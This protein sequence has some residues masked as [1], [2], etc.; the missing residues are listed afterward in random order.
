MWGAP[1]AE[2]GKGPAEA[3]AAGATLEGAR[4]RHVVRLFEQSGSL[5]SLI[6]ENFEV[7]TKCTYFRHS[8]QSSLVNLLNCATVSNIQLWSISMTPERP[9]TPVYVNPLTTTRLLA[10]V[11]SL[12]SCLARLQQEAPP[13]QPNHPLALGSAR[14]QAGVLLSLPDG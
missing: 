8:I 6:F 14:G 10:H 4:G 11:P 9:L 3:G 2:P 13:F 5:S 12:R 1:G 7:P